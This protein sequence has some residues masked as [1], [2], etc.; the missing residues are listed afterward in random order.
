MGHLIP[1][2]ACQRHVR[3]SELSCPFCGVALSDEQRASAAPVLPRRRLGRA[4]LFTFG[5][6]LLGGA[7]CDSD[8]P[9]GKDA[10][11]DASNVDGGGSGGKGGNATGGSGTGGQGGGS[12]GQSGTGGAG[13]GGIAPPYGITPL[14]GA[15][16]SDQ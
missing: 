4:A 10:A 12:G 14:Y 9:G 13:S 7:A 8:A 6:T 5:A 1:C 16:S 3:S 15:P 2:R 11:T